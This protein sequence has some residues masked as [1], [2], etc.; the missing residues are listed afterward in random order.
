MNQLVVNVD[1]RVTAIAI[2]ITFAEACCTIA[3]RLVRILI[4]GTRDA[5]T[6]TDSVRR[7]QRMGSVSRMDRG[8]RRIAANPAVVNK[9]AL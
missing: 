3:V 5:L 6:P 8:W 1:R 9:G 7:G 2:R 4:T